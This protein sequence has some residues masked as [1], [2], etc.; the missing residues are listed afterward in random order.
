[1]KKRSGEGERCEGMEMDGGFVVEWE[2]LMMKMVM[3]L[4]LFLF[5][6]A[7]SLLG[8]PPNIPSFISSALVLLILF[9]VCATRVISATSNQTLPLASCRV[10]TA[11]SQ[12]LCPPPPSSSD[13]TLPAAGS[14][15]DEVN[16]GINACSGG[17]DSEGGAELPTQSAELTERDIQLT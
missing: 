3:V 16:A 17:K 14:S 8:T 9:L 6:T 4:L 10:R 11:C 1:M 5:V 2:D 7:T 15:G 13:R 12:S